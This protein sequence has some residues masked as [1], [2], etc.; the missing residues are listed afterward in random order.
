MSTDPRGPRERAEARFQKP[1]SPQREHVHA[2]NASDARAVDEKTA[3][4]KAL[5]LEKERAEAAQ[6]PVPVAKARPTR[7]PVTR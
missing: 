7:K 1:N 5:R 4:L 6:A 3:R 2:Q